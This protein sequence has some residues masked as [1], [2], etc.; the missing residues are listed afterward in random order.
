MIK[1]SKQDRSA[2]IRLASA[3]P[4]G[5]DERRAVLVGLS[6]TSGHPLGDRTA[7]NKETYEL[8]KNWIADGVREWDK[9]AGKFYLNDLSKAY[10][11]L[12]A[13]EKALG[14]MRDGIGDINRL[15]LQSDYKD[16][17]DELTD[18]GFYGLETAIEE[19]E[20]DLSQ[21]IDKGWADVGYEGAVQQEIE[22]SILPALES[23]MD[24]FKQEFGRPPRIRG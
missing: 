18:S 21:M 8:L 7:V 20:H 16:F 12:G 15:I 6:K 23:A 11:Q 5:S 22:D 19:A 4:V 13:F 1:I 17:Y 14:R 2:L 9:A 3:M 24:D 10:D